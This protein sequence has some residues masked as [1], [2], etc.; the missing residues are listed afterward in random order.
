MKKQNEQLKEKASFLA[1]NLMTERQEL[2]K[3]YYNMKDRIL[4]GNTEHEDKEK[5]Y[6]ECEE[7]KGKVT[8]L[9][10]KHLEFAKDLLYGDVSSRDNVVNYYINKGLSDKTIDNCDMLYTIQEELQCCLN[11]LNR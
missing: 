4:E 11:I 5:L 6:T 1:Q 9:I 10:N 3:K 2:T 7:L 8:I